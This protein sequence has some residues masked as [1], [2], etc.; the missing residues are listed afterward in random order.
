[1]NVFDKIVGPL[2]KK[3]CIIFYVMAVVSFFTFV[4]I[5]G[6]CAYLVLTTMGGRR[7]MKGLGREMGRCF[8]MISH[9][10]IYYIL[11]RMGY[12]ICRNSL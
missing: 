2:D 7:K 12:N 6:R 10:L 5:A 1:M 8:F 9:A 4:V 11:Y 3:Y